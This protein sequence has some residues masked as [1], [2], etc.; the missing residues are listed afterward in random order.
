MHD[1]QQAR[2]AQPKAKA[3][4]HN[5]IKINNKSLDY[6]LDLIE[7]QEQ[8]DTYQGSNHSQVQVLDP[9]RGLEDPESNATK[10]WVE[11]ENL[12]TTEYLS[13]VPNVE[14]IRTKLID[15]QYFNKFSLPEK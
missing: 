1:E 11:A 14:Q 8:V 10:Q 5:K 13:T 15:N 6:P 2:Q 12:I 4:V 3:L 9:Y 7:K